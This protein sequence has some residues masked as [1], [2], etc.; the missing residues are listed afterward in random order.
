MIAIIG[1]Q[2]YVSSAGEVVLLAH[3]SAAVGVDGWVDVA[4]VEDQGGVAARSVR[5]VEDAGDSEVAAGVGDEVPGV[6]VGAG[7]HL[8][9]AEIAA[10]VLL[11]HQRRERDG[12]HGSRGR[13]VAGGR[14]TG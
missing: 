13:W 10:V 7:D 6:G 2:Y 12:I 14:R 9:E 1:V 8:A 11:R 4:V 5:D 3:Q